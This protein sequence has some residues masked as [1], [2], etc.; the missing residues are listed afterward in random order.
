[1]ISRIRADRQRNSESRRLRDFLQLVVLGRE[2][3]RSTAQAGDEAVDADIANELSRGG[4]VIASP[5]A[6]YR[7]RAATAR[8][9]VHHHAS[10]LLERHPAYEVARAHGWS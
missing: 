4:S 7:H 3:L 5:D 2:S 10:F 1:M 9:T 6:C 8:G